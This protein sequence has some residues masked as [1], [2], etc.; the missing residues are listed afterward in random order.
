MRPG[1]RRF[2]GDLN[3]VTLGNGTPPTR[4]TVSRQFLELD[5]EQR[6][7]ERAVVAASELGL[8]PDLSAKWRTVAELGEHATLSYLAASDDDAG[9]NHSPS[10]QAGLVDQADRDITRARDAIRRFNS[11]HQAT[12]NE[13]IGVSASIPRLIAEAK[14]AVALAREALTVIEVAGYR[15]KKARALL[16]EACRLDAAL[17]SPNSGMLE[18]QAGARRLLQLAQSAQAVA[19]DAPSVPERARSGLTSVTTRRLA[20]ATKTD[21]ISGI[22]SILRR[23]FTAS[24]SADLEPA[25]EQAKSALRDAD[26]AIEQARTY[27]HACA[28]E[29]LTD[30]LPTIRAALR[31]AEAEADR[32]LRRLADLRDI[33]ADP[34][35]RQAQVRFQ[36]R[37]AQ[38]FIVARHQ[39]R[40]FGPAL[41][42]QA[43]RLDAAHHLLKR[44]HPDYLLYTN[45]LQA[46]QEAVA[47]VITEAR[48]IGC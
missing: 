35:N 32:V 18:R 4:D 31:R 48:A 6:D 11:T 40:R 38:Q 33:A 10:I 5:N 16:D 23:E 24:C 43:R 14:S 37:D 46:I 22:M 1:K 28:W 30:Q 25:A 9:L 2:A 44:A 34:N 12:L 17:G 26:C 21:R 7:T 42:A 29:E 13:A 27:A 3:G 39:V 36:L 15:S 20:A 41:D 19:T 8:H 45:E 47:K